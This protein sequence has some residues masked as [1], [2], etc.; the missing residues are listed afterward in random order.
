MKKD[1]KPL[2]TF[3]N[4]IWN[5]LGCLF[6]LGCQWLTTVMV[7]RLSS[8]YSNSGLYAFA[9]A[10]GIIFASIAL[11][12][13][14][15]FQVSDLNNQF[16]SAEYI[17]FRI[18]T[19]FIGWIVC[20]VYIPIATSFEPSY[21]F[22]SFLYLIFKSDE[23][24]SD[25]LYGVYQ[26]NGRMDFIGL[27]QLIRGFISLG[28]FTGSLFLSGDLSISIVA[29]TFGC[30]CVTLFYDL[31]HARYFGDIKP[32]FVVSK[33]IDLG[34]IC[35]L[36]MVAS[37]F[38]NSIVSVVRQ[39]FGIVN[40]S[41]ALGYYASV[42]TPAVLIQVAATYLYSPLISSLASDFERGFRDFKTS[43]I[44]ILLTLIVV[45]AFFILLLSLAGNTILV[46]AFGKTIK[47]YCYLFPYVLIATAAVGVLL[48]CN[49]VLI[50]QRRMK[51]ILACNALAFASA[52]GSSFILIDCFG[53]NGINF[54]IILGS[55]VATLTS[56]VCILRNR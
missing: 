17:A 53:M 35:F 7:V 3:Q 36:A 42:A 25:V 6:Y 39:Y 18:I 2:S 29:M 32:N 33:L 56:L 9:M 55:S 1:I 23:S 47:P 28:L 14:R 20:L 15:T 31:P 19:I 34:K 45:M 44:K 51:S 26:K 40:G 22:V 27:S 38:A 46:L 30:F 4:T 54:S 21:I 43:F 24:F 12:K 16:T 5:A 52:L 8:S 37:L 13:V 49:D 41:E 50:I 11:Y 10:S 48:Y